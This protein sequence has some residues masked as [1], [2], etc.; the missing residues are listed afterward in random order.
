MQRMGN[1]AV[2]HSSAVIADVLEEGTHV[3]VRMATE[4]RSVIEGRIVFA[5][6]TV[7]GV[8]QGKRVIVVPWTAIEQVNILEDN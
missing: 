4:R 1:R 2:V 6:E 7:I 3:S 5:L 8:R